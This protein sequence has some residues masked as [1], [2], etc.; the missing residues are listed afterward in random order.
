MWKHEETDKFRTLF[1]ETAVVYRLKIT[2]MEH[3]RQSFFL[4]VSYYKSILYPS[5]K[6]TEKKNNKIK[7][8]AI[9]HIICNF[10]VIFKKQQLP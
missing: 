3:T 8:F 6:I 4:T 2:I 1:S 7:N 10:V 9:Q 5:G